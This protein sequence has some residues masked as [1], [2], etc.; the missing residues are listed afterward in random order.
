MKPKIR[1]HTDKAYTI[2]FSKK[3][4]VLVTFGDT[5]TAYSATAGGGS[6]RSD[7]VPWGA[8]N[9]QLSEMHLLACESPNKWRLMKTRRD[10]IVGRGVYAHKGEDSNKAGLLFKPVYDPDFEAWKEDVE[11]DL[12]FISM[13]LQF[14]FSANVFIKLTFDLSKKLVGLEVIDAFKVRIRKP[15]PKENR[16]SAYL[17]NPNFGTKHYKPAE[18]DVVP[19]FD[20]KDPAKYAVSIL[21]LK[22][23]LPGQDYYAFADW[24]GTKDWA[25][26]TNKIPK[27]HDAGLDNGYNVKLHI[28]IPDN[29]FDKEGLTDEQKEQLKEDTLQGM[30][31]TFAGVENADKILVTFHQTEMLGQKAMPGVQIKPL[32][33]KMSDDAYT[34]LFNTAN[35]AQASG[36]G[37][38]PALAGIDTGGKLGGSGKELE[39]A[40][41]YQQGFLTYTDR[42]IL[43]NVLNIAKRA[44]GWDKELQFDIRN[45]ALYTYD[46]TPG[47]AKQNQ[48]NEG[49]N[50]A[51]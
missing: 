6:N 30:A 20:R 37:V 19:A 10:F 47:A 51:H 22:E 28:S 42:L 34:T 25:K 31:D 24:W 26:V 12:V 32:D 38:L 21:H 13:C 11:F 8:K 2:Q 15:G 33:N 7:F 45:I 17:V 41:N 14:A 5:D 40:A 16:I 44:N 9:D 1:Q 39:A 46:V 43:L 49:E 3:E 50:D 18:T 23:N 29:Y 36:H 27:F 48:K 35:V 4:A